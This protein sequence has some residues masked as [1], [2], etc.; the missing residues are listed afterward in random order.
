MTRGLAFCLATLLAFPAVA[1][2]PPDAGP[3]SPATSPPSPT[4]EARDDRA[5]PLL[6]ASLAAGAVAGAGVVLAAIAQSRIAQLDADP[7]LERY[8]RGV[9]AGRNVCTEAARGLV[10]PNALAPDAVA[11]LCDEAETW[12]IVTFVAI[13]SAVAFAGLASY[14][15]IAHLLGD[16]ERLAFTVDRHGATIHLG[17]RF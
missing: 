6:Y 10:V 11:D 12:E 7:D 16:D 8:R 13:P 3:T 15:G 14:F 2:P 4:P 1:G 5:S 9:T 17:G